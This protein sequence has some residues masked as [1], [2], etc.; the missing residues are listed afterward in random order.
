MSHYFTNDPVASARKTIRFVIRGRAFQM[1]TDSGVFSRS[2]LDFGTRTLLEHT[3]VP[4]DAKILDLGCGFG[5]IGIVLGALF[6]AKVTMTDVNERAADLARENAA[7]NG[8]D[9]AVVTGDGC[10]SVSGLFDVVLTNP[11]IRAGKQV[12]YRLFR[13]ARE[14]LNPGGRFVAVIHHDQGAKTAMRELATIFDT[15]E[16][17]DKHSGYY[18]ISCRK[19]LTA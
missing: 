10:E 7:L 11:P 8:V 12:V 2:G 5:A 18:L 9:A 1:M 4:A 14:K 3:E 16:L 6:G 17:V 15:V 13:E 19:S